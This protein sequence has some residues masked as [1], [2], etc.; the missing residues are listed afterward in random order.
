MH[1]CSQKRFDV[2]VVGG[3]DDV[4]KHVLI[5]VDKVPV[6][7]AD[8]CGPLAGL[9][10]AVLRGRQRVA[11]VVLTVLQDLVIRVA[12]SESKYW[13]LRGNGRPFSAH[14]Q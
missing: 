3:G 7:L 10:L 14:L 1:R 13:P 4:E 12:E 2:K 8:V 9:V 5:D 6:P 11:T